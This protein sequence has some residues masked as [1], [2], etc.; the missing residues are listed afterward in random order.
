MQQ[1]IHF[2]RRLHA[3]NDR[4]WFADHKADYQAAQ[5]RFNSFAETLVQHI[6]RF[7]PS[8]A[9][10]TAKDITYRIY[11]DTRFS[12]DKTPYKTHMGAY[13][14]RGGKKSGYSGYYVQVGVEA[15]AAH[16]GDIRW[17]TQNILAVGDYC[18]PPKVLQ[19]VREDIAGGG[20]D[21]D[22][23][24]KQEA[25]PRFG[26]V[27]DGALKRN[28]KGFDKEAPWSEYLRLKMYCLACSLDETE[29]TAADAP[30]HIARLLQTAK[31][32]LDY[33]N[34]AVDYV[35]EGGT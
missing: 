2:L 19:I 30:E 32:L 4:P 23:I 5:A 21:F 26:L 31:P 6:A 18:L 10:L 3:N 1:V 13:I 7:D 17:N 33:V 25:D 28:P 16:F 8:V 34:R 22:R 20:G 27:T 24:V 35:R 12:T 14:C 29:I 9:G 15:E 11:R